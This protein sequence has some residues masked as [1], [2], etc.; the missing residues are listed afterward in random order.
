MQ[1]YI[2][3]INFLAKDSNALEF[4]TNSP[5]HAAFILQSMLR[6]SQTELFIFSDILSSTA[7]Q[8]AEFLTELEKYLKS[9]KYFY[10]VT[11]K[12]PLSFRKSKA[13]ALVEKYANSKGGNVFIG[14]ASTTVLDTIKNTLGEILRFAVSDKKAYLL[15]IN[16]E[17]FLATTDFNNP[18]VASTLCGLISDQS[19]PNEAKIH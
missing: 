4:D 9:G 2:R 7:F 17:D 14:K 13:L 1:S 5:Y 12:E 10:L 15:E 3:K 18:F 16:K 19:P 6:Y 8:T 11:N